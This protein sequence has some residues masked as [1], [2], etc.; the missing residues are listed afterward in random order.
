MSI[1]TQHRDTATWRRYHYIALDSEDT[2]YVSDSCNHRISIFTAEGQFVSSFSNKG[3]RQG[4]FS[5]PRELAVDRNG[6]VYV[7]DRDN[8]RLQLF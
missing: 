3:K 6:V 1:S 5:S 2:V 4:E 7:C 8:D